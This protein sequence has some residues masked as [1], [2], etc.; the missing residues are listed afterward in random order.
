M[1][2]SGQ[3]PELIRSDELIVKGEVDRVDL[4]LEALKVRA[5]V[6]FTAAGLLAGI[7]IVI[8]SAFTDNSDL[9][10]W[11]TGLVSAIIGAAISYGFSAKRNG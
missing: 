1:A 7:V 8:W 9:Q 4:R 2:D 10:T 11:A 3:K 6:L 5:S